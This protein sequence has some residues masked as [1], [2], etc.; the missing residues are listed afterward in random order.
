MRTH[1]LGFL[2]AGFLGASHGCGNSTAALDGTYHPA[3]AA[4]GGAA[5][6]GATGGDTGLPCDLSMLLQSRCSTCH[7]HPPSQGAPI[8]LVT[9]AD[10]VAPSKKLSTVTYAERALTR[11]QDTQ[12]PMPPPPSSPATGGEVGVLQAWIAAG[13]PHG[14]CGATIGS[15]AGAGGAPSLGAGGS[16]NTSSGVPCEVA[17][18]LN[19]KCLSCHADPPTAGA[20]MPLTTY[21]Q[22]TAPSKSDPTLSFA[23]LAVQR[24]MSVTKPMPPVGATPATPAEIKAISDWVAMKTPPGDCGGGGAGGSG[25]SVETCASGRVY[26]MA[27]TVAAATGAGCSG[28]PAMNPGETCIN[29]HK[30]FTTDADKT[31]IIAGTVYPGLHEKAFCEGVDGTTG[32]LSGMTVAITD[33][34]GKGKTYTLPVGPTGNFYLLTAMATGFTMPYRA[35]VDAPG[36]ATHLMADPRTEGDCNSCHTPQGGGSP[37]SPGR[38]SFP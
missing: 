29:C 17:S 23:A 27:C 10:L 20:V 2:I 7:G 8:P 22:L 28:D 38:I 30:Q 6:G 21:A 32:A 35:R 13:K 36:K 14:S 26:S 37:K 4:A 1:W 3:G 34:D 9:Y 19:D 18:V 31:F 11:M 5:A 12:S 24:M 15:P 16:T 33:H 25:V